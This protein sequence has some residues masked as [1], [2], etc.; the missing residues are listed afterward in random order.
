MGLARS[1]LPGKLL[2]ENSTQ[3]MSQILEDNQ[4]LTNK[5]EGFKGKINSFFYDIFYRKYLWKYSLG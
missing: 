3:N 1:N 5:Q 2:R 4:S